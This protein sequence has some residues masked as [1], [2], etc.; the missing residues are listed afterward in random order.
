[1]T[2]SCR[3]AQRGI[4]VPTHQ[5]RNRSSEAGIDRLGLGYVVEPAVEFENVAGIETA[6][7]FDALVNSFA[8]LR[9]W[10]ALYLQAT[11]SGGVG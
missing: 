7:G 8:A 5:D 11:L 3:P 6:H 2:V 4:S 9:E 10:N 1:L